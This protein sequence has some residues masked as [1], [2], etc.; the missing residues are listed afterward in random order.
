MDYEGKNQTA[1]DH[2]M[3]EAALGQ[4]GSD[5]MGMAQAGASIATT[6]LIPDANNTVVLPDGATLD[7]ISVRGRDL[8]IVL[9]D[10]RTFII[11]D[12]AVYV[13]QIV[14]QGIAVPPLN[15]AALLIGNE[16]E[17]AAGA[18]RSSGGNFEVPVDPLQDAYN[19]GNLLPYTELAFPEAQDRRIFPVVDRK[20]FTTPNP[21]IRLD[22]DA[23]AGG[24]PGGIGDDPNSV[25]ATG[26]LS[27]H[28][29]DGALTYALATTGA[30]AGFSYVANGTGINVFQ[31]ATLV[32]Q[33]TLNSATGAYTVTQVA[34]IQHPAG[35]NE[36]NQVFTL[37]YTVTD[38]DGDV[39]PGTVNIDVDD[40]S[41]V[42]ANDT[43]ALLAGA[44][45]PATGNVLTDA[46]AGDAGDGD[47]GADSLGADGG[48]VT[49]ISG[50]GG[51]GT[52][53]G[54][55]VG[56]HGTLTL[57]ADGSYSYVRS[58]TGAINATDVFTYTVTDGDGDTATATLTITLQDAVPITGANANVQLDDDALAGGNPGGIG[59][60]P[61]AVNISGTLSGSGGD[62]AL[63]WS[64]FSYVPTL[65][66]TAS[67]INPGLIHVFQGATH[68][69]TI[70]LNNATGAYTVTQ[71]APIDHAALGDENN[72][73]FQLNYNVTDAD[74]DVAG[75]SLVIDLDDDTPLTAN[76]TDALLAGATGPATG[77][78]LTD[79]DPGDTG[80]GDTGADSLGAD[81]GSVTAISGS[82]GAGTIGGST[83]GTHGTL[84]MNADGSYSY[85]RSGTGAINA[86][87]VFTYTVTDG[88]GDTATAT[89]TIT[90][91]DA[92]PLVGAN[93][94]VQ[95]DDDAVAGAGGNPGGIGDDPD[96]VNLTGTL[97]GSGGDGTLT[98]ALSTAGA[99][100][101]FSYVANGTGLNVF[102]GA[103]LV[104]QV[105]LNTTNGAYTV[106]QIAPIDHTALGN[107]NNTAFTF[108]YT[109]TDQDGD[110]AGGT[111]GVNV[112]DDTPTLGVVQNQQTDN[113]PATSPAVG[114]L[115]FSD[116]ADGTGSTMTITAN[117]TGITSGGRAILTQQVG[118]VLTGYADNDSSGGITGGDTAVFTLTVNPAAG[119]SG[120][121]VFDLIAPLDGALVN[122]SVGS[123]S[124]FGVGPSNSV[125]VS[126][127]TPVQPLTIVTGWTPTGGF[128][129]AELAAWQAGG[130]P[131]LTQQSNVN[132][133]TAGWGL[134][135]NNFDSGEFLRFDFGVVDDY[136]A[137]GAYVPPVAGP[138]A[139]VSYAT[140]GFTNFGGGDTIILVA[141]Y[142]NGTTASFTRVGGT[143]PNTYTITAPPG[144]QIAW[145]DTY[146]SSGSIKLDLTDLGVTN[147]VVDQTI[148]FT[149]QL[150]DGDG[151]TTTTNNFTV[152]V[153]GS[154]VP[155]T[156]AP[157]VVLDLDGDG[158]EFLAVSAGVTFDYDGDGTGES[159]AWAGSDD[160]L[161]AIDLNG[162]GVVNNGSE[163]VFGG[164]GQTDLEGLAARYDSN[165]DGALTAADA[166]FAQFGVWQDADSDGVTDAGEFRS[167][168]DMGI[169]SIALTS[170]GVEYGAAGGDVTV[171]GQATYTMA[172]GTTG[173]LAD[174]SFAR[175]G[176]P[177]SARSAELVAASSVAAAG[178]LAQMAMEHAGAFA[179]EGMAR[180]EMALTI[181]SDPGLSDTSPLQAQ[182]KGGDVFDP[183]MEPLAK[184]APKPTG[185]FDHGESSAMQGGIGQVTDHSADLHQASGNDN[186][187]SALFSND[188]ASSGM[189]G[190]AS[191]PGAGAAI[192]AHPAVAAALADGAGAQAVDSIVDHFAPDSAGP[193]E[194]ADNK[195]GFDLYG[196]LNMNINGGGEGAMPHFSVM[197]ELDHDQVSALT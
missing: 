36:N 65:G 47:T 115:H 165:G 161:L 133:S 123:G 145:V 170:D 183:V 140:F 184:L 155:F 15:L 35:D 122:V 180:D 56:A 14:S 19:L 127:G 38:A 58:G 166:A 175:T 152:R 196:L 100:G 60:D 96:A 72:A 147:T 164:N 21:D 159:T 109:V 78:V 24:N 89:L 59:D 81:G 181:A 83:T 64:A 37:N 119:T 98:W 73:T 4:T 153:G 116:G 108:G 80:D 48:S 137:G 172:D 70:T 188:H 120:Q 113:N 32:L 86:T 6:A 139:N 146:M 77:N 88:D 5:L 162:D 179:Q 52:I 62:G 157:P 67:L 107:E 54:A 118:N 136:D 138:F 195:D 101:G 20:P 63:T 12:G 42:A 189:L 178:L 125:T 27:G 68:V 167:L 28:G 90:L 79:A 22:D 129:A 74:G 76:D 8:V 197:N 143:D 44:T 18:V 131:T 160:G 95:L 53:G 2:S 30:P 154:L 102:Q 87:D 148:P 194:L 193:M 111:L 33:I 99:P 173:R 121:Y 128:T 182:G 71:L 57:N 34:P 55:T 112:D 92:A 43:D 192:A 61:D 29:G 134:G 51:A 156:P 171:H 85:V 10:G 16:P 93:V 110:T 135:N 1:T 41:P 84:T 9:D 45:G 124:S 39:A 176:E 177:R 66:M 149:L 94:A 25:Q 69:L 117:M 186:S 49:A 142:T 11:P 46:S 23:L 158:A 40:D 31:G 141:H 190:Q 50:A 114:T 168:A 103:T 150:T 174:V 104:M 17:P 3:G 132:G 106:S 13:P 144:L 163:L 151:D 126:G 75:G 105:T 91:Q 26:T 7:D 82:G 185:S 191:V 130:I 97:S 169:T 187:R